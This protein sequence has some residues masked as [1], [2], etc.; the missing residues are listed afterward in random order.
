MQSKI[1]VFLLLLLMSIALVSI[2]VYA[3]EVIEEQ[4]IEDWESYL[5]NDVLP[6]VISSVTV[7]AVLLATIITAVNRVKIAA[8]KFSDSSGSLSVIT[9]NVKTSTTNLNSLTTTVKTTIGD[10]KTSVNAEIKKIGDASI[11][12][13]QELKAQVTSELSILSTQ[14]AQLTKEIGEIKTM[15]KYAF[16]NNSELVRSGIASEIAKVGE[17]DEV[18]I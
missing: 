10:I 6:I 5:V 7:G 18:K 16:T 8:S 1:K 14:N 3:S 17:S 15:L 4:P 11:A 2:P 13:S 9:E 12:T